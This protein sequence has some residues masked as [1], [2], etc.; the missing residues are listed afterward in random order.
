MSTAVPA[1][2]FLELI[3]LHLHRLRRRYNSCSVGAIGLSI[4]H[5]C[6]DVAVVVYDDRLVKSFRPPPPTLK[7]HNFINDNFEVIDSAQQATVNHLVATPDQLAHDSNAH[8]QNVQQGF[9]SRLSNTAPIGLYRRFYDGSTYEH[10]YGG[11]ET[12]RLAFM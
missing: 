6:A 1:R 8:F 11:L 2:H 9:L 5:V 10:G 7:P 3:W 4:D 12:N